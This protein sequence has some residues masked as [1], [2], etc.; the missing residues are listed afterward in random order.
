MRSTETIFS[1]IRKSLTFSRLSGNTAEL[2]AG[3]K[4]SSSLRELY[5][6]SNPWLQAD[7]ENFV[8]M[9][10]NGCKATLLSLGQFTWITKRLSEVFFLHLSLSLFIGLTNSRYRW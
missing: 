8:N 2:C 3:L 5:V 4:Q 7:L 1:L 10:E 9:L 6:G